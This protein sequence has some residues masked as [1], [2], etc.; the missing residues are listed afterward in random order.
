MGPFN[1]V[2]LQH[3]L[4]TLFNY[5]SPPRYTTVSIYSCHLLYRLNIPN[6]EIQAHDI[7][8]DSHSTPS[9]KPWDFGQ[10]M[11]HMK[12]ER[13]YMMRSDIPVKLRSLCPHCVWVRSHY[14]GTEC[15]SLKCYKGRSI[16]FINNFCMPLVIL[17]ESS[18]INSSRVEWNWGFAFTAT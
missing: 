14:K 4:Q 18:K 8:K 12:R 7:A 16:F 9:R 1:P 13:K 15:G 3:V 5:V 11:F 17:H 2:S 10:V 6:C